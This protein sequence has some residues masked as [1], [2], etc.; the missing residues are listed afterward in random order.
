MSWLAERLLHT[1]VVWRELPLVRAERIAVAAS[2]QGAGVC[3]RVRVCVRAC[4]FCS[5]NAPPRGRTGGLALHRHG[6]GLRS[7][8]A[9]F[10]VDVAARRP[11]SRAAAPVNA[12]LA[13]CRGPPP[14]P[15]P[16]RPPAAATPKPQTTPHPP[17][18]AAQRSLAHALTQWTVYTSQVTTL[19]RTRRGCWR[20]RRQSCR[21]SRCRQ[22]GP[23][24]R[25]CSQTDP[26]NHFSDYREL[27]KPHR[28]ESKQGTRLKTKMPWLDLQ[29]VVPR[30]VKPAVCVVWVWVWVSAAVAVALCPCL[31]VG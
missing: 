28:P 15:P 2:L 25:A 4:V 8:A 9:T 16:P 5:T 19:P 29:L 18:V 17:S 22:P 27:S 10:R 12:C 24:S 11:G 13:S 26:R 20:G 14:P 6:Q 21:Y 7:N 3:V 30:L 23:G 31:S 1:A